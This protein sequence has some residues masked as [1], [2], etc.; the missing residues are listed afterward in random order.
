MISIADDFVNVQVKIY[1]ISINEN[2]FFNRVEDIV[3]NEE[4]AYYE[5][6]LTL[7]QFLQKASASDASAGRQ[8]LLID[9]KSV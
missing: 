1:K 2:V 6:S 8:G 4:T 3:A 5:H 7:P 9:I